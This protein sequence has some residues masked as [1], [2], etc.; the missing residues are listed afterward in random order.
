M[1][2]RRGAGE[3]RLLRALHW[4]GSGFQPFD[5]D[6]CAAIPEI[7]AMRHAP[8]PASGGDETARQT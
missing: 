2:R 1:A 7:S 8:P 6:L 3:R 4:D 5:A